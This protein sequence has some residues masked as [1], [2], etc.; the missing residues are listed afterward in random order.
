MWDYAKLIRRY[1]GGPSKPMNPMVDEFEADAYLDGEYDVEMKSEDK[2]VD[3]FEPDN[4]LNDYDDEDVAFE[5][6][7]FYEQEPDVSLDDY[8]TDEISGTHL[9]PD[10]EVVDK[11]SGYGTVTAPCIREGLDLSEQFGEEYITKYEAALEDG[12]LELLKK[13]NQ[14]INIVQ[15]SGDMNNFTAIYRKGA[16]YKKHKPTG[17]TK[18]S[19][20]SR[21][22][23][24]YYQGHEF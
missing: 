1:H 6:R 21:K 2:L 4:Y 15:A 24:S 17:L 5:N 14:G 7:L 9:V 8:P 11:L 3:E 20:E 19:E 12:T 23:E 18:R 10:P 13:A 22:V 16:V